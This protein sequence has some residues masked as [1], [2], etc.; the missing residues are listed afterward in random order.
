MLLSAP[1][2]CLHKTFV[3]KSS[4]PQNPADLEL[5]KNCRSTLFIPINTF[6]QMDRRYFMLMPAFY[7]NLVTYYHN[8]SATVPCSYS[9]AMWANAVSFMLYLMQ[10]FIFN[11][12]I[13]RRHTNTSYEFGFVEAFVHFA[14]VNS[15]FYHSGDKRNC[16]GFSWKLKRFVRIFATGLELNIIP[17]Q[18]CLTDWQKR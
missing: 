15:A 16:I 7:I 2:K 1:Y 9:A 3:R 18:R 4:T 6:S 10:I 17:C 5:M 14:P 13:S 11:I 8:A 12:K